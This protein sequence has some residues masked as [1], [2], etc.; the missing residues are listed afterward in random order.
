[1]R[2]DLDLDTFVADVLEF[3]ADQNEA[4]AAFM[5]ERDY[6]IDDIREAA[7]KLFERAGRGSVF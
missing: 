1:M 4:F 6:D 5:A 2:P 3:A 7:A